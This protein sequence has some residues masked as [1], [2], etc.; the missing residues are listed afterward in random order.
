MKQD[1]NVFKL[2]MALGIGI[3]LCVDLSFASTEGDFGSSYKALPHQLQGIMNTGENL[4]HLYLTQTQV[5][6]LYVSIL[7]RASEGAGNSYCRSSQ[8]GMVETA[9]NILATEEANAYFKDALENNYEFI[10][11]IYKNVLG[12][13]Y[14]EDSGEI[15]HWVASLESGMSK[16]AVVVAL[17]N[18]VM[19][20]QYADMAAQDQFINK[21]GVSNY[22]ADTL[23]KITNRVDFKWFLDGVSNA[24]ST[25]LD[26]KIN[27]DEYGENDQSDLTQTQVSQLY[28]MLLGRASEGA[29]N[30]YWR[31]SQGGMVET[32]EAILAT[33][34]AK[35]Y[36]KDALEDNHE[37]ITY[38]YKNTL[39]KTYDEDRGGIDYWVAALESG[40]SKGAVVV[41][42]IN[43]VMDLQHVGMA[44]QDQFVNKVEIS[45]YTDDIFFNIMDRVAFKWF[46]RDIT[47][48]PSTLTHARRTVDEYHEVSDGAVLIWEGDYK[49]TDIDDIKK[50]SGYFAITGNLAVGEWFL[51]PTAITSLTGL[52]SLKIISG[53]L[54]I[55]GNP[56]LS[57]LKGLDNLISVESL[58]IV[59]NDSLTSLEGLGNINSLKSLW[60]DDNPFLAS[61]EG[62]E[63][64]TSID[65]LSIWN[66]PSLENLKQLDGITAVKSLSLHGGISLE[67]LDHIVSVGGDL[68][69][70]FMASQASL[71]GLGNIAS[72][73][74]NLSI[75]FCNG[76]TSLEGLDSLTLIGGNLSIEKCDAL[77]TLKGLEKLTSVGGALSIRYND[78]LENIGFFNNLSLVNR[79]YITGNHSLTSLEMS[80]NLTSLDTL[81]ISE[82]DRV[83]DF[84]D[85][86]SVQKLH[87]RDVEHFEGLENITFVK[88]LHIDGVTSFAGLNSLTSVENLTISNMTNLKGFDGLT[89]INNL[90]MSNM[91]DIEGLNHITS[92]ENLAVTNMTSLKGLE[93][94]TSIGRNLEISGSASLKTLDGLNNIVSVGGNI[95][96]AYYNNSLINLK[97][98][99]NLIS[100]G[101]ISLLGNASIKNFEGLYSLTSLG[102]VSAYRNDSLI[103]FSG[104]ENITSV[105][106]IGAS[107]NASLSSFEG[108]DNIT[109][110]GAL[111]I[112]ISSNGS[113]TSLAGLNNI[114]ST[115]EL[116][117]DRNDSLTSLDLDSLNSVGNHLGEEYRKTFFITNNKEL[118]TYHA[119]S[120]KDQVQKGEGLNAEIRIT[121]NKTCP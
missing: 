113:L 59:S 77:K 62:L 5:S 38:I 83:N 76:L 89:S 40:M 86:T 58:Y 11:H 91:G 55:N 20:P 21:V 105:T 80:S 31:S 35:A 71:E 46:I 53:T 19:D 24:P 108:L 26:A 48:L 37:F 98:L 32:A 61:L 112:K 18:A 110:V 42:L 60:I 56:S 116:T 66:N 85:L 14:D 88:N 81:L 36:F 33:D 29:G 74:G 3:I 73:G 114:V 78:S 12:K 49:I 13:T 63:N 17:I 23:F 1:G 99:D 93:H 41:S 104:L 43:T 25:V 45:N 4:Q 97:G 115:E 70:W 101:G 69:I 52:E 64:I 15:D 65:Y 6:Q 111:G 79:L 90:F 119:E 10:T 27:V 118:C 57:S 95:F 117:I 54:S 44:I 9:E 100:A 102:S 28:V 47:D 30:S 16:G 72:V 82:M 107:N 34:E 7:G 103:N 8:G 94:F 50:L 75:N 39:G 2:V 121:G 109:S 106:G 96:I 84:D 68:S 51:N 120:L 22:T 67:G 92:V 87:I